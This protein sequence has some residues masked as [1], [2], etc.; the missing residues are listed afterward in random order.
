MEVVPGEKSSNEPDPPYD[1]RDE[2][3]IGEVGIEKRKLANT[4]ATHFPCWPAQSGLQFIMRGVDL[5]DEGDIE[6]ASMNESG[7]LPQKAGPS[8]IWEN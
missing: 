6:G 8:R 1:S 2:A 4:D 3:G 5:E 7:I